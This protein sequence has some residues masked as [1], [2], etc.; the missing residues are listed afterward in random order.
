MNFWLS[1]T[2]GQ[3]YYAPQVQPDRGLNSWPPV[4]DSPFH[5]TEMPALT[6]HNCYKVE[7]YI[8][9]F[10]KIELPVCNNTK[11]LLS[12]QLTVSKIG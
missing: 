2:L 8:T 10:W 7:E 11:S 3:K 1:T 12:A 6:T 5:V 4:H 9:H